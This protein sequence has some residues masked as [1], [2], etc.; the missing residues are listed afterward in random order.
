MAGDL[1]SDEQLKENWEDFL[2]K[3]NQ[4]TEIEAGRAK[5]DEMKRT[6]V[7][8]EAIYSSKECGKCVM[9]AV[10]CMLECACMH[11]T[12]HNNFT[13]LLMFFISLVNELHGEY[14]LKF[15]AFLIAPKTKRLLVYRFEVSVFVYSNTQ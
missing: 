2:T 12:M 7:E 14:G 15:L 3:V 10:V 5:L 8:E 1:L 9:Y 4:K 13:C 11:V 6:L